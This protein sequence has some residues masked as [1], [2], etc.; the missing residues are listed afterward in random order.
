MRLIPVDDS[1]RRELIILLFA[2]E[3]LFYSSVVLLAFLITLA[4]FKKDAFLVF[5]PIVT[6]IGIEMAFIEAEFGKQHRMSGQLVVIVQQADRRFV[7]H[8]EDI[9]VIGVMAQ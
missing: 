8:H 7:H 9:Q 2:V 4:V 3:R 5:L 1:T 6:V